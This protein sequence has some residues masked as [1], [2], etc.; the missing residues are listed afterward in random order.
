MKLQERLE[1]LG[2]KQDNIA[3]I[4]KDIDEIVKKKTD[5]LENSL[6]ISNDNY[7]QLKEKYE[8]VN[9]QFKNEMVDQVTSKLTISKDLKEALIQLTPL[10]DNDFNSKETLQKKFEEKIEAYPAVFNKTPTNLGDGQYKKPENPFTSEQPP[11][12]PNSKFN[13]EMPK[14]TDH[15]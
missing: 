5:P 9:K 11:V 4:N 10:E 14:P 3:L 15:L 1:S 6:K 12:N 7:G 2:L 8:T 13:K